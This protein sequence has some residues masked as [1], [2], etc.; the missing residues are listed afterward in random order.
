M[1][2]DDSLPTL[3][4]LLI[5][6]SSAG[7]SAL[8]MRYCEDVF[9]PESATATIGID[10]KIKKLS[11]RG[12]AY[13]LTLF[14][15]AGQE[16]FRTLSTSYYRGAHGVILVYDASSRTSFASMERWF[17]E[18][19]VNTVPGV[20]LYLVG[21][22]VDK[23]RAV[24]AAEGQALADAHGANFCEVS[25]KTRENVRKPF[26]EI[27]DA[28]VSHPDVMRAADGGSKGT[29]NVGEDEAASSCSC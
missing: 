25:A 14:D 8:L 9:E 11:V 6:P 12:K 10:F 16:R 4:I 5:G 22:K 29:V 28:V 21:A 18:V 24:T 13:R 17:D 7:K 3:K 2:S 1:A 20:A 27:V 15:T 23:P 19:E 26:V